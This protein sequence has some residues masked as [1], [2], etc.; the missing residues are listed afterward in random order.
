MTYRGSTSIRLSF[1]PDRMRALSL[2]DSQAPVQREDHGTTGAFDA[3]PALTAQTFARFGDHTAP[4]SLLETFG[5]VTRCDP[6]SQA[7][8]FTG[9]P[10]GDSA[11]NASGVMTYLEQAG[12]SFAGIVITDLFGWCPD[13]RLPALTAPD[14]P[15]GITGTLSG[16]RFAGATHT[17]TSGVA[18]LV[19]E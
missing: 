19:V 17:I 8:Q 9:D 6:F 13:G 14:I 18:G 16:L 1:Q 4:R 3:W 15:R 2:R 12:A 7:P 5:K 10:T 11:V